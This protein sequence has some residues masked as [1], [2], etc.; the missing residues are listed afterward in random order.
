[1]PG[2]G[3]ETSDSRIESAFSQAVWSKMPEQGSFANLQ[4][5]GNLSSSENGCG[6]DCVNRLLFCVVGDSERRHCPATVRPWRGKVRD[7]PV[8]AFG[9]NSSN[10]SRKKRKGTK[11]V[12]PQC[13]SGGSDEPASLVVV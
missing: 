9:R 1:M 4:V 13:L 5:A 6:S 7:N 3:L 2:Q 11:K 12:K 10:H 8:A